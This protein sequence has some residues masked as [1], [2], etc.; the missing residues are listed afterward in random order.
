MIRAPRAF[1]LTASLAFLALSCADGTV[2]RA[3]APARTYPAGIV[4]LR[5]R[6]VIHEHGLFEPSPEECST[7]TL[8]GDKVILGS[9]AGRIVAVDTKDGH[10]L[11]T[12]QIS[13]GL[14]SEARYDPVRR[15]VYLGADDGF[16]HALDPDT[17]AI[18]W[19]HKARGAVERAP[20]LDAASVYLTTAEDRVIAL[21]AATGKFR[22]QYERDT[23][24]GFTIHGHA[25]LRLGNDVL[26][27]GFSDGFLVALRPATGEVSWARSL[28]A[29][30]EQYVDVDSTPTPVGDLLVASSFSG[31]LYAV[32]ASGGDIK[33]RLGIEGASTARAIGDR[34][35][36]AAP[37]DGVA[38]I[39][40][41]GHLIWRQALAEAG[42]LTPPQSAG[43][44]LIFTGSRA[45]LFVVDRK[46][47]QLLETF[48]PG[49][50]ICGGVALDA[51]GSNLYVLVNSG[52]LYALHLAGVGNQ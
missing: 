24:D 1:G 52:A 31:G 16:M 40:H 34:L 7:P 29:A 18:R 44:Y 19:S 23:P 30:S 17:G 26:Y 20:E 42:E 45:G 25:G 33:W 3:D 2:R 41:Q 28:A 9:R 43:P 39:D 10:P 12:T 27:T 13:G 37:R 48:N 46:G 35:Y 4:D 50:G 21:D 38:A 11:W 15:Q 47:G 8:V 36:F 14:D 51:T 22:W 6:Q 32:T 49:R 5:W